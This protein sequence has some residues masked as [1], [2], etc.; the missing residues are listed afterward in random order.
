MLTVAKCG[1]KRDLVTSPN[2]VIQRA[3]QCVALSIFPP[4]VTIIF[5]LLSVRARCTA[6]TQSQVGRDN[7]RFVFE[8]SESKVRIVANNHGN[9]LTKSDLPSIWGTRVSPPY[10]FNFN[11]RKQPTRND[12]KPSCVHLK[13]PTMCFYTSGLMR[14]QCV[15]PYAK[16]QASKI[17]PTKYHP[18][19]PSTFPFYIENINPKQST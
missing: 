14:W 12:T 6:F 7:Y 4:D 16:K 3:A 15:Q 2:E 10:T 13:W 11:K 18:P 17:K 1:G 5:S 9:T 19:P 8:P